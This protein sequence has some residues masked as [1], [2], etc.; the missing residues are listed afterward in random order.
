M[1]VMNAMSDDPKDVSAFKCE[2]ATD[3]QKILNEL[4]CFVAAMRQLPVKPH[5][6]AQAGRNP[7]QRDRDNQGFPIEHE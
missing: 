2:R 6:D 3:S 5:A 7:P 1:R 4:W